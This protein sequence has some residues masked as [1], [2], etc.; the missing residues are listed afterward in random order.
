LHKSFSFSDLLDGSAG[1]IFRDSDIA[2]IK[3]GRDK[4]F[5]TPHAMAFLEGTPTVTP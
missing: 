2:W 4:A 3:V 1:E 5:S